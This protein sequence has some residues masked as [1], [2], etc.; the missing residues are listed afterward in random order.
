MVRGVPT[1]FSAPV[2][3]GRLMGM[4]EYSHV[5]PYAE[6]HMTG[7][8]IKPLFKSAPEAAVNDDCL[9]GLLALV[10]AVR[11]GNAREAS[12]ARGELGKRLLNHG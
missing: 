2:L 3:D 4:G 1:S 6:G 5:W 8:S 12:L 9:Y 10:D 11:I 7:Q